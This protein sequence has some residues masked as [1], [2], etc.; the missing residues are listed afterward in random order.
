MEDTRSQILFESFKLFLKHGYREVS[1]ND[2]VQASGLSK[3][4]FYHYF[5]SK[6]ELFRASVEEYFFNF[7]NTFQPDL[8]LTL[9]ENLRQVLEYKRIAYSELLSKTQLADLDTGYFTLIFSVLRQVP[10]FR[11]RIATFSKKEHVLFQTLFEHARNKGEIK[12]SLNPSM[13]SS[14]YASMLDG[15]ELHSVFEGGIGTLYPKELEAT[16]SFYEMIKA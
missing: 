7:D 2:L 8:R 9:L 13:L 10:E 14:M 11:A 1:M 5:S 4:A 15:I 16:I 12:E 6:D 3:G